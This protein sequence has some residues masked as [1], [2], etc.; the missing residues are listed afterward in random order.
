MIGWIAVGVVFQDAPR[1]SKSACLK[2]RISKRRGGALKQGWKMNKKQ[3][4]W[5]TEKPSDAKRWEG[6]DLGAVL[7]ND[8]YRERLFRLY[9][10]YVKQWNDIELDHSRSLADHTHQICGAKVVGSTNMFILQ[11]SQNGTE[12]W[13][14]EIVYARGFKQ[15]Y[16]G[17]STG[18]NTMR[19]PEN[20][21]SIRLHWKD[22]GR[23]AFNA[24]LNQEAQINSDK[25]EWD[26]YKS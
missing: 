25:G 16:P 10:R 12:D 23:D 4:Y 21:K 8:D 24:W 19:S 9:R 22:A 7:E 2:P 5:L 15:F 17:M 26:E 1:I 20:I 6:C 3:P 13:T 14:L 18:R 11:G